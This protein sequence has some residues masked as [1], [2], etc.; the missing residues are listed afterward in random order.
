MRHD[1]T[2]AL[3][4]GSSYEKAF[5]FSEGFIS[6]G[7]QPPLLLDIFAPMVVSG[8][9]ILFMGRVDKETSPFKVLEKLCPHNKPLIKRIDV[10]ELPK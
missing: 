7:G 9:T 6:K 8:V 4:I 10:P 1:L 3:A 5:S 2:C